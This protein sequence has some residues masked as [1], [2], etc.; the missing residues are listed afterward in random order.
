M[1]S[2][3]KLATKNITASLIVNILTFPLQFIN[4]YYIVRYLGITYLGITSLYSNIL[5]MLSLADLG[6]GTAIVFL[7]YKPLATHNN[8]KVAILMQY[9]RKIYRLIA[10]I[11]FL[12]G[13][14]IIPFLHIFLH[15][16]VSYP[17]VYLLFLVYLFGTASSYLYSYNQSLLYADQR[18]R[19][20]SWINLVVSYVMMT[21]QIIT[22]ILFK[23][24]ILY[25]ILYVFTSFITNVFV[26][27][28][29]NKQYKIDNNVKGKLDKDESKELKSN[30]IGNMFVRISGVLVTSTDSMLL[31]AFSTVI[32]VGLYTNYL[33]VTNVIANLMTQIMGNLTGSIGNYS[34]NS[35]RKKSKQLFLNLQFLN[36]LLLNWATLGIIFA[37]KDV[38]SM[39]L[40]NKYVLSLFDTILIAI[41]FYLMNYRMLG[42]SFIAVYGLAKYMKIF[43]ISEILVNLIASFIFLKYFHMGI[44]GVV[45]GTICSTLLTV[46]WQD[47]YI[48]FHHAFNS[49]SREYFK[50]YLRNIIIIIVEVIVLILLDEFWLKNI[51]NSLLH[52]FLIILMLLL[53]GLVFP[54]IFYI[55]R[56]EGQYFFNLLKQVVKFLK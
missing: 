9:Y 30:V 27:I 11:I 13:I 26:S 4:R 34:V 1:A 41:S 37:S 25:A 51:E 7:L 20:Y 38:I 17:N 52:L 15:Q 22:G 32:Q 49:R 21:A 31:S 33:T 55:K 56:Q 18:N 44:A 29:V 36:F 14:V 39:W 48:I 28:Y 8:K 50:Q 23:N 10:L 54:L 19:I 2:R 46:S 45:L 42:W 12:L 35:S 43:S 24:P 3:T 53:I 40:G 6:I 5:S 47:P 16:S